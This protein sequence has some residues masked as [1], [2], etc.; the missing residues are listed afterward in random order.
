MPVFDFAIVFCYRFLGSSQTVVHPDRMENVFVFGTV[1]WRGNLSFL[2]VLRPIARLIDPP[3]L[4][5]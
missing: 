3:F 2:H 1:I 4:S 5:L